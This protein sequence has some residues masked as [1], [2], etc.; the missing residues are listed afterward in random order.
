VRRPEFIA[1][2]GGRPSGL[3]GEAVAR[4]MAHET[5]EANRRALDLLD[6]QPDDRFLDVG[7]GAGQ[8]LTAAASKVA[9]GFLA[10]IDHSEVMFRLARATNASLL[11]CG[12][13]QLICADSTVI[14]YPDGCFNK[15]LSIHT[16]YFWKDVEVQLKELRRVVSGGGCL[17]IGYRPSDDKRFVQEFPPAVYRI[18]S[19]DETEKLVARAGFL[20]VRT[21]RRQAQSHCMAW[22]VAGG[23]RVAANR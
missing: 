4:I 22:T 21:I 10:G 15:A 16:V 9:R 1:R 17:V 2:Q 18:R 11:Q 3:L 23:H 8:T 20:N 7:C 5:A 12:R 6:L 14:P 19:V 13:L